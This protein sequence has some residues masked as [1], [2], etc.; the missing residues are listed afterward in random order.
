MTAF[1][2]A[3]IALYV[4]HMLGDHI[5]QTDEIAGGKAGKGWP[6]FWAMTDHIAGY[7]ICQALA[8]LGVVLVGAQLS[9]VGGLVGLAVS[10]G[11]HAFIDRRWPV[12][13]LLHHTGSADF[14]AM[15]GRPL[16]GPYLADQALHVAACFIAAL[17]IGALS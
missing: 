16:N 12:V 7:G 17:L 9:V 3:F 14:A 5:A 10:L 8:L 1:T 11:S 2:A 13:W 15:D 6:A 4:G